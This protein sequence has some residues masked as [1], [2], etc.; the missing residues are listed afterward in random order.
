MVNIPIK[1]E[2]GQKIRNWTVIEFDEKNINKMTYYICECKCGKRSSK[3]ICDLIRV[4]PKQCKSCA[5]KERNFGAFGRNNSPDMT[6]KKI[7]KWTVLKKDD[8]GKLPIHWKCQCECGNINIVSGTKLRRAKSLQCKSCASRKVAITHGMATRGKIAPEYNSWSQMKTRCLNPNDKKYS[9]YGGRG[10]KVFLEWI[11][12]FERFFAY[13][14]KK[15]T[16]IHSIDR[17]DVDGNYEPGN[18][19]WASPKEQA[20]NRRKVPVIASYNGL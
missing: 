10:I 12:S 13:M 6:G 11:N 15:P 1:V 18:V 16:P 20:N 17:I 3:A 8:S 7:G 4:G 14:G 9:I 5:C 2:I 19:R